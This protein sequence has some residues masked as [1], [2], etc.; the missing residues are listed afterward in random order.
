MYVLTF[1]IFYKGS[2]EPG[3]NTL[4][5]VYSVALSGS[6]SGSYSGSGNNTLQLSTASTKVIA[7]TPGFL[8][9]QTVF[10]TIMNDYPATS[11]YGMY[12]SHLRVFVVVPHTNLTPL[13]FVSPSYLSSSFQ[14]MQC[15]N[16]LGEIANAATLNPQLNLWT[17]G[18]VILVSAAWVASDGSVK[19]SS[20][21]PLLLHGIFFFSFSC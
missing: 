3:N 12:V 10:D 20:S 9:N 13:K 15:Q 5:C 17:P 11:I 16:F 21:V 1:K 4:N 7:V 19:N 6:S 14:L 2:L 18:T 8:Q